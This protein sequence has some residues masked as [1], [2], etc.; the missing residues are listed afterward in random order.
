MGKVTSFRLPSKTVQM[1]AEMSEETGVSKSALV[2]MAVAL[3]YRQFHTDQATGQAV[4]GQ[5]GNKVETVLQDTLRSQPEA[6]GNA[7]EG[8]DESQD[9]LEEWRRERREEERRKREKRKKEK[10]KRKRR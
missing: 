10:K 5:P 3:L 7:Q 1:L 8:L 2:Q 6:P 4:V 9:V